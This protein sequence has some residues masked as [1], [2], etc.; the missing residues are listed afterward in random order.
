MDVASDLVITA[1]EAQ[2]VLDV[3]EIQSVLL[4]PRTIAL[5]VTTVGILSEIGTHL[6]RRREIWLL[7]GT[8][9]VAEKADA[10]ASVR[11]RETVIVVMVVSEIL[12]VIL[13]KVDGMESVAPSEGP[14]EAVD[15]VG[16]SEETW[17]ATSDER[18]AAHEMME[19]ERDTVRKDRT[20]G[21]GRRD[22]DDRWGASRR[23]GNGI[24]L[25]WFVRWVGDDTFLLLFSLHCTHALGGVFHL[26][27]ETQKC[28]SRHFLA[29]WRG[30]IDLHYRFF[31]WNVKSK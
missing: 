24:H 1:G 28:F 19:E 8:Q 31:G 6:D 5:E 18:V 27:A 26:Q 21:E 4:D 20:W 11:G 2:G 14:K 3:T 25:G 30:L 17:G 23:D 22:Q 10:N 29:R 15:V 12:H 7:A 13:M 16:R 9:A